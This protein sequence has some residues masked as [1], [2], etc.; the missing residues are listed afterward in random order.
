MSISVLLLLI[1]SILYSHNLGLKDNLAKEFSLSGI[2]LI[3]SIAP[4]TFLEADSVNPEDVPYHMFVGGAD[5]DVDGSPRRIVMSMPIYERAWGP[6]QLT[7][8]QGAG[9]NVFNDESWDEGVR[10]KGA[11]EALLRHIPICLWDRVFP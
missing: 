10:Y 11:L 3:S 5:G 2:K 1:N 7:Y 6:R 9:H 8:V 4:T